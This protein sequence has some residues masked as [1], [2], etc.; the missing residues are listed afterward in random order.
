MSAVHASVIEEFFFILKD[1]IV[2]VAK[3]MQGISGD[4][5]I[6]D[7]AAFVYVVLPG[8][9]RGVLCVSYHH[10]GPHRII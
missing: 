5:A 9:G 4:A 3:N 6:A 2:F 7:T 1:L 8:R 10:L